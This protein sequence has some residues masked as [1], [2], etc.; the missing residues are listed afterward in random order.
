MKW[1]VVALILVPI[2][3]GAAQA[4]QARRPRPTRVIIETGR[5]NSPFECDTAKARDWYGSAERCR[6]D[7]CR[8]QNES[9]AYVDGPDGR[10][11]QNPCDHRLRR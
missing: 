2:S 5:P 8:G 11:R 10:L 4:K 7:L 1:L 3:L 9:N 6:E